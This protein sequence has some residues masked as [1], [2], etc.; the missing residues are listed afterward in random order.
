MPPEQ[1][2]L[3]VV[4]QTESV[5]LGGDFKQTEDGGLGG[6]GRHWQMASWKAMY[7]VQRVLLTPRRVFSLSLII[8][9]V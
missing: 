2:V 6:K 3:L 1:R 5:S 8:F 9:S 7:L 4:K